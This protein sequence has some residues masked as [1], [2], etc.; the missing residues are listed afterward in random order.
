MTADFFH[1]CLG[2]AFTGIWILIGQI[3]VGDV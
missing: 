3:L 1:A 2:I